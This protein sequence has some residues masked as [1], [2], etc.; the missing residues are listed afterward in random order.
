MRAQSHTE[1]MTS[2]PQMKPR[3][4]S[5]IKSK[6][7]ERRLSLSLAGVRAGS[8]IIA[9]RA[10]D[11]WLAPEQ[12]RLKRSEIL[13]EQAMQFADELGQLKG[14][15]V[16]IGQ[17]LALLGEHV[18][19]PELTEALHTLEHQTMALEW[20]ALE[21]RVA[22]ELGARYDELTI[23]PEPIGAASLGQ[24]HRAS[25]QHDRR[26]LCL[27]IQYPG[28][29]DAIDSDFNDVVALLR[30]ANWL[31][32]GREVEEWLMEI[33]HLLTLEVDYRHEA[34]MTRAIA[35][36]VARDPRFQVPAVI[37]RYCTDNILALEYLPG[38]VVSEEEVQQLSLRRRNQ[39]GKA[40]LDLL[41]TEI[42]DWGIM[43]T[44]P[45][46]GN[47]RIR[48]DAGG[49]RLALLDF[50]AVRKLD[51]KFLEALRHTIAAAHHNDLADTIQGCLGLGCIQH[52]HPDEIKELFARFCMSLLEPL[53]PIDDQVPAHAVNSRGQY[54]WRESGLLKRAGKLAAKSALSTH[55]IVPPKEFALITRKLTGVFTFISVLGCE[56]NGHD[57]LERHVQRWERR[58]RRRR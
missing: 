32:A 35:K 49:D 56:F 34:R 18:L 47:Y 55:F 5:R 11:W 4:L 6:R 25:R 20:S 29:R 17:L 30:L 22:A 54:R 58:P 43:Q 53:R 57:I 27:K 33:R 19:P 10:T 21:D 13:A 24:V 40:M 37:D 16:K 28:I 2:K 50:G 45:N 38:L 23:D 36:L 41:L 52:S 42:Y 14:S 51:P 7:L 15:Y 8:A 48:L 26:D 3:T 44:D 1:S 9:G 39:L 46:F 12:R 31:P